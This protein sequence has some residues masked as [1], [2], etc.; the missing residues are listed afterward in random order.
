MTGDLLPV[1]RVELSAGAT[2]AF[3]F[4]EGDQVVEQFGR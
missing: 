3:S 2:S 1:I 4:H